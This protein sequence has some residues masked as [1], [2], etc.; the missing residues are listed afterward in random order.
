MKKL[1]LTAIAALMATQAYAEID[2]RN[3]YARSGI[4]GATTGAAFMTLVNTGFSDDRLIDIITDVARK[5]EIHTTVM[6]DGIAQMRELDDGIA[7]PAGGQHVLMRGGDHIM[8]MGLV[9]PLVQDGTIRI[10]LVF[11]QA[12]ELLIEIPVDYLATDPIGSNGALITPDPMPEVEGDTPETTEP[13]EP[14]I[15]EE[16]QE[17]MPPANPVSD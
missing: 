6:V 8:L 15:E 12:G 16:V 10:T 11:E 7:L 5:A 9:E 14:A 2:V 13:T 3:A 4:P 1:L 17:P